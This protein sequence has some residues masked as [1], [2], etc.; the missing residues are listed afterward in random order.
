[1]KTAQYLPAVAGEMQDTG[2]RMGA[3]ILHP[4]SCILHQIFFLTLFLGAAISAAAGNAAEVGAPIEVAAKAEGTRSQ[5]WA[6]AAWCEGAKCWLLAW[7]EGFLNE[8]DK[9]SDIWCARVSADGKALDP[10][11]IRL[12]KG[13][14]LKDRPRVASDGRNFL[15]VWEDLSNGKAWNVY[16][17]RVSGE[18]KPLD[19][20]GIL[21]AGGESNQC[22]P[23]VAFA[24]GNYHVAWMS[25]N[26]GYSVLNAR[27]SPEGRLLDAKGLAIFDFKK[28]LS[29]QAISPALASNGSDLIARVDAVG[30]RYGGGG[31][32]FRA[33]DGATGGATGAIQNC[34]QKGETIRGSVTAGKDGFLLS[35]T[36]GVT[37]SRPSTIN[38]ARLD[39]S[40]AP[41][42][43]ALAL[44]AYSLPK[45]GYL[46]PFLNRG[47]MSVGRYGI[48]FDG[49]AYL[50]V[51]ELDVKGRQIAGW[52]V[53][54]EGK[55]LDDA[56][57]GFAIAAE[58]GRN[59]ILPFAA[60]GPE[61]A[62]LVVYS[63]L[64]GADDVKVLARVV[65]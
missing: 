48:A 9:G 14:G 26:D 25:F 42:D 52:R 53:S 20:D 50:V 28:G 13:K 15:V 1:M 31:C 17:A 11:G 23:D 29:N 33:L 58:P 2:C 60:G 16:A 21:V 10:A 40:G 37:G 47:R 38:L 34:E 43:G 59:E 7:R 32:A 3:V 62:S 18:G 63:E 36:T 12:T 41:A 22:R 35:Y 46:T 45:S 4:A 6:S 49:K 24:K 5:T 55:L 27:V 51:T 30:D 44:D 57:K 54:P 61:G 56:G 19:A 64:R 65:K 8:A 39:K